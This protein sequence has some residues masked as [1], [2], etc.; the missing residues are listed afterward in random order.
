MIFKKNVNRAERIA[1]IIAGLSLLAC[2]VVVPH[3]SPLGWAVS[4]AGA[5]SLA[6]GFARYCPACDLAGRKPCDDR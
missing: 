4:L 6:T 3:M 1:R 2:G 5:V